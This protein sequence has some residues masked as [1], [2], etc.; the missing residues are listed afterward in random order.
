MREA[1]SETLRM[2]LN[3][4]LSVFGALLMLFAMAGEWIFRKIKLFSIAIFEYSFKFD[5]L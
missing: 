4:W 2:G 5:D 3:V 1:L